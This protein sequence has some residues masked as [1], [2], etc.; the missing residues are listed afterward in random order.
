MATT[1]VPGVHIPTGQ[2]RRVLRPI[3]KIA[4]PERNIGRERAQ[5]TKQTA[6]RAVTIPG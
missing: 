6:L 5:H 1:L 4:I 2:Q 3:R